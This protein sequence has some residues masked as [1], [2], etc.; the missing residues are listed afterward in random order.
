MRVLFGS[1]FL[2]GSLATA[3][4]P[5]PGCRGPSDCP[6]GFVCSG[7]SC[8]RPGA[9]RDGDG[10][11]DRLD[12]C[13]DLD[14]A[15][16]P[17]PLPDLLDDQLDRDGDGTG[18]LCDN[19]PRVHNPRQRDADGDGTGDVCAGP[20]VEER[21]VRN[22]SPAMAP[23]LPL[24]RT[25]EGYCDLPDPEG[26]RDHFLVQV[27]AGDALAFDVR[28][29]PD[30]SRMDP[31]VSVLDAA[32]YG[33][34]FARM[35]D[36]AADGTRSHLEVFFH[37]AGDYLVVVEHYPN[38]IRRLRPDGTLPEG[39]L[40]FGYRLRA[41][42]LAIPPRNL[43]FAP[44]DIE[45][46]LTPG[47]V[48]ALRLDP[49]GP[50]LLR[51]DA[52]GGGV[53]DPAVAVSEPASGRVLGFNDNRGDCPGS[54]DASLR[55]CLGGVPVLVWLDHLG[56]GG[57][58]ARLQVRIEISTPLDADRIASGLPA[59]GGTRMFRLPAPTGPVLSLR[60]E[61]D[62][63]SPSL[64]LVGCE[65]DGGPHPGLLAVGRAGPAGSA[66]VEFLVADRTAGSD[67]DRV[68]DRTLYVA[69]VGDRG[70][71]AAPCETSA[72]DAPGFTFQATTRPLAPRDPPA[73]SFVIEPAQG[74]ITAYRIGA[75]PDQRIEIDA[76]PDDAA[77][78]LPF[79][80]LTGEDGTPILSRATTP[81]AD[82]PA[83]ARLEWLHPSNQSL[84]LLVS[85]M[86]GGGGDGSKV[87]MSISRTP[88]PAPVE[89]EEPPPNDRPESAQ[90]LPAGDLLVAGHLDPASGDA[91]D[92]YAMPVRSGDRLRLSTW[93]ADPA[94]V[95]DTV[96]TLLDPQG[97]VLD[98][99]DDRGGDRLAALPPHAVRR[100]AALLACVELRGERPAGYRLEVAIEPVPDGTEVEPVPGDLLVNEVLAEPAQGDDLPPFVE[101]VS[102]CP[103]PIDLGGTAVV[104]AGGALAFPAGVRLPPDQA[105]LVFWGRPEGDFAVP[106]YAGGGQGDWLVPGA[107]AV[108]VLAGGG[109]AGRPLCE[110]FV[111]GGLPEGE[112]ANRIVDA[113][114]LRILRPHTHVVG[115]AGL[116]SPGRR[117]NGQPFR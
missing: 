85:G 49:P 89:E 82:P 97:R 56:L 24:G 50:A 51:V 17:P 10:I 91:A 32:G 90:H 78:L 3:C 58:P 76:R 48:R 117:A 36:D 44:A 100:A 30:D 65:R 43:P 103:Y 101:L 21:E 47:S 41:R 8:I 66:A 111:P 53:A 25:V 87:E 102:L 6:G 79:L 57:D 35:N 88:A 26:D 34:S 22:D 5:D 96:L 13:P 98:F 70:A 62:G 112:S 40:D 81:L 93:T 52:A 18:D 108:R 4:S 31:V 29:W 1:L 84:N 86:Q 16:L 110:V 61:A 107:G 114:P 109:H 94:S 104:G 64:E 2:L 15:R 23:R 63:F 68:S 28:P 74:G 71:L 116:R 115:S 27:E 55:V 54:P 12:R 39:G 19:C 60:A 67:S 37:Q 20:V 46:E 11:P 75:R 83:G 77:G 73:G 9:D 95:P 42:A 92:C 72:P 99:A 105:V 69:C 38:Y 106:V 33:S 7:G 45:V 80:M 59:G 14:P 113:D